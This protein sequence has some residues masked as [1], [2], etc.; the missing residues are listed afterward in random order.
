MIVL[1]L[2]LILRCY[3]LFVLVK[4]DGFDLVSKSNCLLLLKK[5]DGVVF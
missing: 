5:C 4:Y 2:D 3:C 1:S